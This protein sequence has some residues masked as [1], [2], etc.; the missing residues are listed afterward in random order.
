MN[1][2]PFVASLFCA[3]LTAS[4]SAAEPTPTATPEATT[5][6]KAPNASAVRR[7]ED[8]VITFT[9][10]DG[11]PLEA[12]LSLPVDRSGPVPVV[13]NLHGA[14]PRNFDHAL[15]IR[16]KDGQRQV[17]N[18]YDYH[19]DQLAQRGVA[20]FR[21]SKR[22]CR[23]E[24]SGFPKVDRAV[25][26]KTTP[27]SLLDDYRKGLETLRGRGEIDAG[28][29]VLFGSSEGTKLAPLL[30]QQSPE[31]VAG[32]LL[33]SYAPDNQKDTVV[34]Q[35]TVGPW[36]NVQKLI[37]A[38]ADGTLTIEEHGE[39]VKKDEA[40]GKRLPFEHL[41][42]DKDGKVTT[43]EMARLVRPRLDAILKAVE[44]KDDNFLWQHVVNL[45]SAYLLDGWE[46]EPTH[47]RLQ[48]L[49]VPIAIFHG[50]MDGACRV[51]GVRETEAALRAAGKSNVIVK[52]YPDHDHDLN[53]TPQTA[54][55]GG[56]VP[57]QE[58]FT[59]AAEWVKATR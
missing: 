29:I 43:E 11:T 8:I 10:T 38:A 56:P 59:L 50:E 32:V 46:G 16:D 1:H 14:G 25:F 44:E 36:R 58:A 24:P 15:R 22:G 30:A 26:S 33:M 28:R 34:W 52:I 39:A 21:M 13:F 2:T 7:F 31:G 45:S 53:W 51:E 40:L 20:F 48:K 37:P 19:A 42:K 54:A 57:F 5:A 55:D 27:T 3:A 17:I 35:N 41:D 6:T 23:S 9:A 4:V 18:Y 12:K 47:V 49:T